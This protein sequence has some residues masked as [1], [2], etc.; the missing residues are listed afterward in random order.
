MT[1]LEVAPQ[2]LIT[3]GTKWTAVESGELATFVGMKVPPPSAVVTNERR[4]TGGPVHH[5]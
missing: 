4:T 1:E 5:P 3:Y 2:T